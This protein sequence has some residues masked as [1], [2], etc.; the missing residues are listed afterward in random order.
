MKSTLT[1][2]LFLSLCAS[3]IKAQT[4]SK[5]ETGK[6]T[7]YGKKFNNRKTASG[8]IYKRDIF[9]C[10]HRTYPFGTKLLIKNLKND[11]EVVVEVID[12][13]PFKKGRVVDISY[14][15]A[16]ELDMIHHGVTTV[17]VSEYI[18]PDTL[19]LLEASIQLKT[20]TIVEPLAN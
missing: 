16:K 4:P 5:V 20:D 12:R 9:V 7:Y 19:G 10:A 18:V 13:G 2:L 3:V 8:T 15:A 6:A 11:K 17:E 14:I 1:L